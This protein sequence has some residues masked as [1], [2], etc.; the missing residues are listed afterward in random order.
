MNKRRRFESREIKDVRN[1]LRSYCKDDVKSQ[2]NRSIERSESGES[3][4]NETIESG[5]ESRAKE[6]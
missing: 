5:I 6:E 3:R 1:G 4:V 2:F